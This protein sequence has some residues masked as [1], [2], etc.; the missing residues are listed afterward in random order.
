M[1]YTKN[2]NKWNIKKKILDEKNAPNPKTRDIWWAYTGL[3]VGNEQNGGNK[4]F[5]RPVLIFKKFNKKIFLSLPLTNKEKDNKFHFKTIYNEKS[6][7]IILSQ[8]KLMSSKRLR[9]KIR[10]L[11]EQEFNKIQQKL[12]GLI[13]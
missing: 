3:N 12:K 6:S 10:R 5:Q 11:D 9:R 13:F 1:K 7:F 8:I 4:S 2:F